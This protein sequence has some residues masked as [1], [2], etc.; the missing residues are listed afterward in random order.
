MARLLFLGASISQLPAI[1]YA[2]L[3]GHEVVACDGDPRA[4]GFPSCDV[5]E[6]IDFSDVE[7][8][9]AVGRR[10]RV[11]G[12]LAICTDRAV[13]PAALVAERLGLPGVDVD[14]AHAMTHKPTMRRVLAA[15]GL[16][17]PAY[18]VVT[19]ESAR[20][21]LA[22]VP[23]PAV[24]KPADS[25]GQR[26]LFQIDRA[27][28]LAARL[29]ETLAASRGGEALL[30]EYVDGSELNTLF[31]VRAGEPVL[32]T[33]SDRLRPSGPGFGVGWIHR[34]PSEL[35]AS[36]VAEVVDVAAAAIRALGLRDGIAFPQV[37]SSTRGAYVVEVAARIAAGQMA[38]L[39]RYGTG[40]E[41]FEIAI[42]QAIGQPVVDSLVS[43]R[44][45]QPVAI[46][47]L[48]ASPGH[49][50]V[51]RVTAIRNLDEVKL[52]EGVVDA[53]LYFDVGAEI[54]PVQVDA[55][56]RGYVVATGATS[57]EALEHA[58]AAAA[59]L[60]VEV[61]GAPRRRS[62]RTRVAPLAICLAL[63]AG[64]AAVFGLTERAKLQHALIEG[65]RVDKTFSPICRCPTR[66]AHI[67]FRLM[68]RARVSI[69]LVN[70][71]DVLVATLVHD[72]VLRA[73]VLHLTWNG[74]GRHDRVLPTASYFPDVSFLALGRTLRLPSPIALDTDR[75][76]IDQATLERGRT[77]IVR[78]R[79]GEPAQAAL[80]VNGARVVLT[81][82]A[83]TTGA[84]RVAAR[85]LD[86]ARPARVSLVAIDPAGN[87]SRPFVFGSGAAAT[88]R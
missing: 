36:A 40:I 44:F 14:V 84:I 6:A 79:F 83:P 39:V 37:I 49:L 50:P 88:E 26:G 87:R 73:G 4:V 3:V 55:D 45:H 64:T 76:R 86:G 32:L 56:R 51:G 70:R 33:V 30:E 29:P 81:R 65:T 62:R 43:P 46:R 67:A 77:D 42:A 69:G 7:R 28:D 18:R 16:R 53:G 47:F 66:V 11:D 52:S 27:S 34:Y 60:V 61:E 5:A 80:F 48:T 15:A 35:P 10:E 23:L 57:G 71:S 31:V 22:A 63:L 9:T 12:V 20:S 59:K 82:F 38:D 17:Q 19:G 68:R 58:N 1:R 24:L 78:Y 8:V 74:R 21:D 75:P 54:E 41:L 85:L 13:V 2:K 25:G 72:R